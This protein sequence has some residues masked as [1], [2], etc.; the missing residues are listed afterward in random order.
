MDRMVVQPLSK[1]LLHIKLRKFKTMVVK[2][3]KTGLTLIEILVVLG[4]MA[5]LVGLL[6][7]A[8]T[9]V[10]NSAKEVKQ[11]AQF[12]AINLALITFKNDYGD[13]PPSSCPLGSNYCGSQKLSEALL[14][15]DLLGFHPKSVFKAD[16]KDNSGVFIYDT[17]DPQ[18]LNQRKDTYLDSETA[19][20]FRLGDVP[21]GS[22]TGLFSV[23]SPLA[24]NTYV[25]CDVYGAKKVLRSDGKSVLAGSPILYYKAN[26]SK[27]LINEIYDVL[28]N[29]SLVYLKEQTYNTEQPLCR[30][31]NNYE[32]FYN[33]IRD[34]QKEALAQPYRPDSYILISAGLDG[35][36]G[37]SDDI[38]HFG[39]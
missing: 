38:R 16:G 36:Y 11:K 3:K 14:G 9:T 13:Y 7:P 26:N 31:A 17:T 24:A 4:I 12:S 35:I 1:N 15:W 28:D 18:L 27:K 21:A 23:S 29:D 22:G 39:N 20:A 5:L 19:N 10:K 32:Y 25:L 2:S 34:P 37:T 30:T 8:L 6:L 33:Y